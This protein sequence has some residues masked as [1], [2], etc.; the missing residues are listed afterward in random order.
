MPTWYLNW[1][2]AGTMAAASSARH[3]RHE[4]QKFET[5][6]ARVLLAW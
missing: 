4:G 1:L 2:T 3:A 6:I 5:P